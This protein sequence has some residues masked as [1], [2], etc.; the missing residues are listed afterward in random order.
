MTDGSRNMASHSA[1]GLVIFL[2]LEKPDLGTTKF[3]L[4]TTAQKW[5]WASQAA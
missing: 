4:H 5:T 1:D 3:S 2:H